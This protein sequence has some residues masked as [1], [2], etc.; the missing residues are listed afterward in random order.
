MRRIALILLLAL[1]PSLLPG[2][3]TWTDARKQEMADKVRQEFLFAWNGYKTYAWG[4]DEVRPISRTAKDW[5]GPSL[6]MTPV[7]ALDTMT[8]MGLDD[9]AAKTREYIA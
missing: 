9:E 8:L 1:F 5:Y 6:L 4:H 3:N 2:Q 7:D